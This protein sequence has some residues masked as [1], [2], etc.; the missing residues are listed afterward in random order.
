MEKLT[1]CGVFVCNPVKKTVKQDAVFSYEEPMETEEL[2]EEL[3]D[4]VN[5]VNVAECCDAGEVFGVATKP[6][7]AFS[8]IFIVYSNILKAWL[9]IPKYDYDA[10]TVNEQMLVDFLKEGNPI[11]DIEVPEEEEVINDNEEFIVDTNTLVT[12]LTDVFVSEVLNEISYD[13]INDYL[14]PEDTQGNAIS[15]VINDI[16]VEGYTDPE[17]DEYEPMQSTLDMTADFVTWVDNLWAEAEKSNDKKAQ[18]FIRWMSAASIKTLL[19]EHPFLFA[20]E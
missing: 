5:D 6:E 12:E 2:A 7:P 16:V 11:L 10:L 1:Y 8:D 9:T 18:R 13:V 17:K 3:L 15:T 19:E 20:D 14:N 4:L